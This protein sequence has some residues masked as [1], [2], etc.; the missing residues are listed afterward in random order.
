MIAFY[1]LGIFYI[2]WE[3]YSYGRSGGGRVE[4][5][6]MVDGLDANDTA[7]AI[8]TAI[9][10]LIYYIIEGKKWQKVSALF[11]LSFIANAVILINSRGAFL[12][13]VIGIVYMMI[14]I[15]TNNSVENP[16]KIKILTGIIVGIGLFIYLTDS[17]FWDR[18][19]TLI[20]IAEQIEE[21]EDI[22]RIYFW[23]KTFDL[24]SEYPLGTGIAGYIYLSPTFLPEE[25][26]TSGRRAVHSTYFQALAEYGY[27]GIMLFGGIIYSN[28]KT[29]ARAKKHLLSI[30][31]LRIYFLGVAIEA[32]FISYLIAIIFID[33]LYSVVLYWLM[34]FIACFYNI[35]VIKTDGKN[36]NGVLA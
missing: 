29:M 30:N 35:N 9:P 16:K 36:F 1:V 27:I 3:A 12:G 23:I 22:G 8:I 15:I 6:G 24:V 20:G 19:K 10:L 34:L 5:M 25:V 7:A 4:G 28:I 31:E 32:S 18:M 26:L 21:G 2:G 17:A 14:L 33:R 11:A 13:L